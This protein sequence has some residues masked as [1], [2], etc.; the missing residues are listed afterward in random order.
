VIEFVYELFEDTIV[1]PNALTT[2]AKDVTVSSVPQ[3]NVGN[4]GID[5]NEQEMELYNLVQSDIESENAVVANR[6]QIMDRK[7]DELRSKIKNSMDEYKTYCESIVMDKYLEENGNDFY[8]TSVTK[9]NVETVRIKCG[10]ALY[11]SKFFDVTKWWMK[12]ETKFPELAM[13]ASILL[14]KPTHNAFQERVFS[15]GTY[16]DTK[17]RKRLKEEYFEMSV[18]N[19]VNGKHIDDIYHIMQPSIMLREKD[20]QKELKL[21]IEK[22]KNELDLST[23]IDSGDD[24]NDS[25]HEYGSVCSEKTNDEELSDDDE[26]DT[27]NN[28]LSK[29]DVTSD[30]Q[31]SKLV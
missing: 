18:M 23:I 20:R 1:E 31:L 25:V 15:R 17:L 4:N 28:A 29:L 19:A 9:K 27:G 6:Q 21:F 30:E 24:D 13:G 5:I 12:H 7:R 11:V 16:S 3:M 8:K 10:D 14:G 26:D 22:R 2:L